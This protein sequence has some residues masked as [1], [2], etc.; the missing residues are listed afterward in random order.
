[1]HLSRVSDAPIPESR[2]NDV[3]IAFDERTAKVFG[4]PVQEQIFSVAVMSYPTPAVFTWPAGFTQESSSLFDG[5]VTVVD[6]TVMVDDDVTHV[7]S[8]RSGQSELS[9]QI[10]I[11]IK[12]RGDFMMQM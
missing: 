3:T 4:P 9:S 5:D 6:V 2:Y 1:M 10:T 11:E 12:L 8:V 7:V